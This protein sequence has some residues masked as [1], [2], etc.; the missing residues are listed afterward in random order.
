MISFYRSAADIC[1]EF[2]IDLSPKNIEFIESQMRSKFVSILN[3]PV[4]KLKAERKDS[5]LGRRNQIESTLIELLIIKT[6]I[7]EE[8]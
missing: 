2:N 7:L 4:H 5:S 1:I 3:T 8:V 6:D